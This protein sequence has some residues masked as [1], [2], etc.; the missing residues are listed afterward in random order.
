VLGMY[1]IDFHVIEFQSPPKEGVLRIFI[2]LKIPSPR[3]GLNPRPLGPVDQLSIPEAGRG[4]MHWAHEVA[5]RCADSCGWIRPASCSAAFVALPSAFSQL[6]LE[7]RYT[8]RG[9]Q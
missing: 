2:V 6:T 7:T 5:S 3:P 4:R 1:K 8:S 9:L